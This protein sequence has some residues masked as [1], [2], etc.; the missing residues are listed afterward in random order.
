MTNINLCKEFKCPYWGNTTQ[1]FG[2]KRY[3]S[4]MHCIGNQIKDVV[5]DEYR[6]NIDSGK[7][8]GNVENLMAFAIEFAQKRDKEREQLL[9]NQLL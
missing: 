9:N 7:M 8:N 1:D 5:G 4:A 2:C 3:L 6:L